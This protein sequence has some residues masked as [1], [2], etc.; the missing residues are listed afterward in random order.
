MI[1]MQVKINLAIDFMEHY[2]ELKQLK[3][4]IQFELIL[5]HFE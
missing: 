3:V 2:W 1:T 4:I 5:E